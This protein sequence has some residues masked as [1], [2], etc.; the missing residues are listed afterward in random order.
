MI[1]Q[2]KGVTRWPGGLLLALSPQ[3]VYNPLDSVRQPA[4]P[5]PGAR[6]IRAVA[7][8]FADQVVRQLTA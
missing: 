7:R 1:Y 2:G 8:R 4:G 3:G 6:D 5:Y